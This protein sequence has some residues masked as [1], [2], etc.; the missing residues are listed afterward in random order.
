MIAV[1]VDNFQMALLRGLEKVKQEV[2]RGVGPVDQLGTHEEGAQRLE[3]RE[4]AASGAGEHGTMT[5]LR[6]LLPEGCPGQ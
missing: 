6:S 5:G 4:E 1:L 3:G 2:L